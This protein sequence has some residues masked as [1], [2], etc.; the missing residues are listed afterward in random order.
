MSEPSAVLAAIQ[1]GEAD[2]L[3]ALLAEN[4]SLVSARDAGGVSAIMQAL[5]YRRQDLLDLLL[6]SAHQLDIF[7]ASATGGKDRVAE[8]LRTDPSLAAAWSADGFTPL[9]FASFF[10]R[11]EV[12]LL[13]LQNGAEVAA[14]SRNPMQ[15]MPLHSA[16]AARSLAIVRLLL[17]HDAPPNARQQQGWTALHSAAQNGDQAMVEL[18]LKHGA[19]RSA[20]NDAGVTPSALA[21]QS[22]HPHIAHILA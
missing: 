17:E 18:L 11:D 3:R 15:V 2:K 1:S 13:L 19:D 21:A 9:H 8:L 22:G 20:A 10:A 7:E 5:Y 12:A 14:L 4:P 6:A 16:A